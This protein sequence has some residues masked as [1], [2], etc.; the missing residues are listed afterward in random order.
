MTSTASPIRILVINPFG[1]G[2]I[3]FTTPLIRAVKEA[4]PDCY[5][6]YWCNQRVSPLLE[7]SPRIDKVYALN[8]G[9]LKKIYRRSALAGIF[10]S[11][12]LIRWLARERFEICFD[13]S[14]DH[15][16][17]L[18][19]KITGIRRRI[20]FNY[21]GRGRF[22]THKIDISGYHDKH[23]V[24]YYLDLLRFLNIEARDKALEL[25]VTEGA[26]AK[27]RNMLAAR[28][29]E[30]GVPVVG[31]APGAGGSWGKDAGY[32][33]WPALKFAQVAD[34][35]VDELKAKVLILGDETEQP[36]ADVIINAM[37]NKP[38]DL[39]GKV[40]LENLPAVMN[41]CSLLL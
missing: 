3:L 18:L 37:R 36:I 14:L 8:R 24:E 11:L 21:K 41:H 34:K 9:D 1:I 19:A 7:S 20:G 10:S 2:D 16:Y 23:V 35:L 28:G 4:Y 29:I 40:K 5:I 38:T 27:A 15:R 17:S 31:I 39:T 13:F 22:L 30:E 12:K 33:H 25:A 6:G 32:K 26:K